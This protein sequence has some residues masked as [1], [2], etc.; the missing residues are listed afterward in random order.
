MH[1][2]RAV[3]L[4]S[5][6]LALVLPATALAKKVRFTV[7]TDPVAE[8]RVFVNG[9]FQGVAPADITLHIP[10]KSVVVITVEKDGAVGNWPK[11]VAA[12]DLK[13]LVRVRL[14]KDE[15]YESTVADDVA[16]TWLTIEP[17]KTLGEDGLPD[18]DKIWQKLVSVVTDNFSDLEQMDRQSYYLRTAWRVRD[19][20]YVTMR[21]RLVVKLGVGQNFAIKVQLESM[22]AEKT[23]TS[24]TV[25]EEDFKPYG[26]VLRSD[27]ET[28]EFLR[29]QL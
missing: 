29:D 3:V 14:E 18:Q 6:L 7:D 10:K 15:A 12:S 22:R 16:N 8:G 23:N 27:K 2:V 9:E 26:R 5:L 24:D 13:G 21:N 25:T 20:G 11:R 4:S 17:N 28:M 19:Y 1:L